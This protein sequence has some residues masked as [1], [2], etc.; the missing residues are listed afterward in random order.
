MIHNRF[1]QIIARAINKIVPKNNSKAVFIPHANGKTDR[2]D[3]I[4]YKSDN[5]LCLINYLISNQKYNFLQKILF[6]YNSSRL[7]EYVEYAHNIN[8]NCNIL[9]LPYSYLS[10][11][12]ELL[13]CKYCF[14]D[15]AYY[16][17]TFKSKSQIFC[18]LGYFSPF[19]EDYLWSASRVSFV[20]EEEF[21]HSFRIHN[22]SFDYYFTS[23]DLASRIL[24]IDTGISYCKFH[25]LGMPRNDIFIN[26]NKNVREWLRDNI[27]ISFSKLIVYT[28]TFRDYDEAEDLNPF[29]YHESIEEL[30]NVLKKYNA[31]IIVKLHPKKKH[32]INC[33]DSRIISYGNLNSSY[34]LYE[35][36]SVSDVLITDY[37]S[38]Y[39]DYL[40]LDKPVIFNH[41]DF[42][43]YKA[44][45]G[46][47][48]NPIS[49]LM[50][51]EVSINYQD[52]CQAIE[53]SLTS[54]SSKEKRKF[55]H[56]LMNSAD[57]S[58]SCGKISDFIFSK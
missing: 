21:K 2:Y 17:F 46:F 38:T 26:P 35:Y 37:T 16:N 52:F 51:G 3:I 54:D 8:P 55:V 25:P 6:I 20:T 43:L 22:R 34:T 36:L 10:V 32:I 15:Q 4:N 58:C 24:S 30:E 57:P 50:A 18:S 44:K 11:Y 33:D 29:G 49:A 53:K 12:K 40:Y 23:S 48:L 56:D 13:T 7:N 9:F 14:T 39:F 19:K 1:V 42:D 47:S 28:P 45:R 5:V 31:I 41:Y 27:G